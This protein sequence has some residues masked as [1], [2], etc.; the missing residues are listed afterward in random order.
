MF[1]FGIIFIIVGCYCN[2]NII[3]D[4]TWYDTSNDT[5]NAF[6]YINDSNNTMDIDSNSETCN[7]QINPY[8]HAIY[9][10]YPETTI[11]EKTFECKYKSEQIS[12]FWANAFNIKSSLDDYIGFSFMLNGQTVGFTRHKPSNGIECLISSNN[13]NTNDTG[14]FYISPE[15]RAVPT[16]ISANQPFTIKF[17]S[18]I[19]HNI[20]DDVCLFQ[21]IFDITVQCHKAPTSSP[22][23]EP[24]IAPSMKTESP[25]ETPTERYITTMNPSL[26]PTISPTILPSNIPTETPTYI[27]T[28]LPSLSPTE[29]SS[30]IITSTDGYYSESSNQ[31]L[32]NWFNDK[33]HII[34]LLCGCVGV[35]FIVIIGI[36]VILCY[37]YGKNKAMKAEISLFPVDSVNIHTNKGTPSGI[38]VLVDNDTC[39]SNSNSITVDNINIDSYKMT[40]K[41]KS[42]DKIN[43]SRVTS[44][45]HFNDESNNDD[46]IT[47]NIGEIDHGTLTNT[48]GNDVFNRNNSI[49]STSAIFEQIN[50][51]NRVKTPRNDIDVDNQ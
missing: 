39:T 41:S 19:H 4:G 18:R 30:V 6:K 1:N 24:T 37:C 26:N 21:A 44:G 17:E 16:I 36:L 42:Y 11:F 23:S 22:T 32:S 15:R 29:T 33:E 49:S 13:C 2:D 20:S 25:T 48:E 5:F 51:N 14:S 7:A 34:L 8:Y 45:N 3:I 40:P 10:S 28:T 46:V 12:I 27:P 31:G 9:Y 43:I 38:P 35:M 47:S 50:D